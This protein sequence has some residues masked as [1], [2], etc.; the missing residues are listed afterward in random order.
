MSVFSNEVEAQP[1]K[2]LEML[3]VFEGENYS[4]I[5]AGAEL[6]R[7]ANTIVFSG[8]GTS[9]FAPGCILSEIRKVKPTFVVEASEMEYCVNDLVGRKDALVLISQSGESVELINVV[10]KAKGNVSI[11]SITN[12]PEST[13]AKYGDVV[14]LLH[15]GEETSITNKTFTN[16]MAAL[17]LLC[18]CV[19]GKDITDTMT[20]LKTSSFE[21]E[22]IIRNRQDEI[23][24]IA[25]YM[26]PADTIHFIGRNG[27]SMTI[28]NQSALI[29]MEGAAC[30]ARAFSSNA[31]RH[32]PIEIC[33]EKHRVIVYHCVN[34]EDEIMR[35]LVNQMALHGSRICVVS[36]EPHENALNFALKASTPRRFSMEA[37]IFM[38]CVLILVASIRNR[39]AGE[40]LITHKVCI[41]E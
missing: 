14:I 12:N 37:A 19:M 8:M 31:F 33:S 39:V 7:K 5:K 11:L 22:E 1:A 24:I 16:T 23:R 15:A 3:D 36:N 41:A 10:R 20:E 28:A 4:S 26:A 30:N 6:L 38:E 32:G 40:F 25:D 35:N 18:D 21:M 27:V 13:L 9:Y 2:L 34:D 17:Y 29:F